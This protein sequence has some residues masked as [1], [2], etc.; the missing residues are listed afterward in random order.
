MASEV[1]RRVGHNRLS[2]LSIPVQT[3]EVGTLKKRLTL[4]I[5][6]VALLAATLPLL[7]GCAASTHIVNATVYGTG[8]SGLTEAAR[9]AD[10]ALAEIAKSEEIAAPVTRE[11]GK[12]LIASDAAYPPLEYSAKIVTQEGDKESQSDPQT[13][14]FEIDLATAIAKKL[15]LEPV[16]VTVAYSDIQSALSEGKA[17]IA[18][19]GMITSPGL[20][21]QLTSTDTYLAA[22]LAICTRNGVE[23]A[24]ADALQGKVVG[25]QQ[26]SICESAVDSIPGIAEKILSLHVL[27]AFDDLMDGKVDALVVVRPVAKWILATKPE[28]ANALHISGSIETGEGYAMWATKGN[29]GLVAAIDAALQ[30]LMEAPGVATPE[31]TATQET[32]QPAE[33]LYQLLLE[34]WGLATD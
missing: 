4:T 32:V 10:Q 31:T 23:Y 15:G 26:G 16:F 13:V 18:A 28:Y 3:R 2:V 5:I 6:L 33:S 19:S 29:E 14:G 9:T 34:K 17:D 20:L 21:T 22:D 7:G 27:G 12:L 11:A 24:D 8:S 1:Y 30:E 25:V